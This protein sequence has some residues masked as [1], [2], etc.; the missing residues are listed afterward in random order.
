MFFLGAGRRV[1]WL[2]WAH[3]ERHG[4]LQVAYTSQMGLST[5]RSLMNIKKKPYLVKLQLEPRESIERG[6]TRKCGKLK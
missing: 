5:T 6:S 4:Q 3:V 1:W 2:C